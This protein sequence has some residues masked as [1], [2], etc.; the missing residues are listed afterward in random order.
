[1]VLDEHSGLFS[2]FDVNKGNKKLLKASGLLS[3]I[4]PR[5]KFIEKNLN[6]YCTWH[7]K[8]CKW[9]CTFDIREWRA[10]YMLLL[11]SQRGGTESGYLCV[12]AS[13]WVSAASVYMGGRE[14]RDEGEPLQN[15]SNP[16]IWT[17]TGIHC[18]FQYKT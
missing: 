13:E 17:R 7:E 16:M 15:L 10:V 18:P 14:G 2:P 3:R 4:C 6:K 12:H 9:E 8:D 11:I 5:V 1:M